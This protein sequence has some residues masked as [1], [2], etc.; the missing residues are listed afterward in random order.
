MAEGESEGAVETSALERENAMGGPQFNPPLYR[1]R[2]EA[3]TAAC[4]RLQAAKVCLQ[5]P[6]WLC[7]HVSINGVPVPTRGGGYG[8]CRVQAAAV[9]DQGEECERAGWSGCAGLPAG[10][11]PAP[12]K[13]SHHRLCPAQRTASHSSPHA[14]CLVL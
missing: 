11:P 8:M 14:R 7:C 12:T 5:P 13:A 10:G 4:R 9:T 3:V 2:Y 6:T 1:Q